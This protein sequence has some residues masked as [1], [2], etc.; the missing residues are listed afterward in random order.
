MNTNTLAK[1]YDSLTPEERFPLI[2]AASARGDN[3]ELERLARSAP[4]EA[5]RVP[6][7]YG[8]SE[9]FM[10]C[11]LLHH[12]ELLNAALLL[13][14]VLAL[15][16]ET[17]PREEKLNARLDNL[18]GIFAYLVTV[19]ADAWERFAKELNVEP[20]FILGE[21]PISNMEEVVSTARAL[22]FSVEEVKAWRPTGLPKEVEIEVRT[23]DGELEGL[24]KA[25]KL[26]VN[27]WS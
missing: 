13:W 5:Y 21:L 23:V 9:G 10:T 26:W 19:H 6:Y 20:K 24:R 14:R 16:A 3:V 25:L 8:L 7:F 27:L 12:M 17:S 11:A 1:N 22:A 4:R 18:V 15:Q 2:L